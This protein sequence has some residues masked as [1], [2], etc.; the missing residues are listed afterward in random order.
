M[1]FYPKGLHSAYSKRSF[2][3]LN[4]WTEDFKSATKFVSCC[5]QKGKFDLEENCGKNKY[6]VMGAG[7]KKK[8][9]LK[10]KYDML[11]LIILLT[12]DITQHILLSKAK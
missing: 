2:Q 7:P 12:L 1:G 6:C 10:E 9:A 4:R 5:L 3:E 8:K 11:Y